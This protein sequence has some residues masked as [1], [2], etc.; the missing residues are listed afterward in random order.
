MHYERGAKKILR[1]FREEFHKV[2]FQKIEERPRGGGEVRQRR[3]AD[4]DDLRRVER[5]DAHA[6]R[7]GAAIERVVHGEAETG[8]DH[9]VG[10]KG[11]HRGKFEIRRDAAARENARVEDFANSFG[12]SGS[13]AISALVAQNR[14]AGKEERVKESFRSSLLLMLAMG[15]AMSLIMYSNASTAVGFMLGTRSGA[16]FDKFCEV[17]PLTE[18]RGKGVTFLR[19]HEVFAHMGKPCRKRKTFVR[20]ALCLLNFCKVKLFYNSSK[21]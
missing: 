21:W 18:M 2:R 6:A 5:Q 10:R 11:I 7:K 16:A 9:R 15:L 14:G 3:R 17:S 4:L 13:A 19:K 12:D 20:D 1:F 8:L